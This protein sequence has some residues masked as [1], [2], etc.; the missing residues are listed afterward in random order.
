[1]PWEKRPRLARALTDA[2]VLLAEG[3]AAP[4]AVGELPVLPPPP[5]LGAWK[6]GLLNLGD[7]TRPTLAPRTV[8]KRMVENRG[9]VER[10]LLK[11]GLRG[12]ATRT[13][14]T[15]EPLGAENLGEVKRT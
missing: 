14:W 15:R 5:T 9:D 1:M 3:R 8:E 7:A 12:R 11:F 2:A 6:R 13:F 10:T 4:E